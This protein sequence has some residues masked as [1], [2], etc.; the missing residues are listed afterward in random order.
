MSQVFEGQLTGE[1][2]KMAI[3]VSRFIVH[4]CLGKK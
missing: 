4:L 2:L 3:V 1:D